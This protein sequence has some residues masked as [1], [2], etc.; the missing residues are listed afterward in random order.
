MVYTRTAETADAYIE[1][2]AHEI[3]KNHRVRVASSDSLEQLIILGQGALRVSASAFHEEV[4]LAER[5]LRGLVDRTNIP[6]LRR[7]VAEALR[8]A[9][10]KNE[11]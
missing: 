10:E 5:E 9:E 6:Q 8:E 1:K 11:E 2:T 4:E 3:A 7:Q